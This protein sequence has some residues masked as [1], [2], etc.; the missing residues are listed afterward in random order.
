MVK[1]ETRHTRVFI[2]SLEKIAK[3]KKD[4]VFWSGDK[5]LL[6]SNNVNIDA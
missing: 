2:E 5:E 4:S 3:L 6:Y 1:R